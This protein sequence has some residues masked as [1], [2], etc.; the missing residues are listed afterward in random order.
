MLE[1]W[2]GHAFDAAVLHDRGEEVEV[3]VFEPP[4][5]ARCVG[6]TAAGVPAEG[7]AQRISLVAADASNPVEPQV[8]FAWPAD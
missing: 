2:L 5:F 6:T 3:F 4:V 8:T 7:T 1:P